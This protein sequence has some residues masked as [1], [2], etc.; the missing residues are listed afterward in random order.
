MSPSTIIA[1]DNQQAKIEVTNDVPYVS[2]SAAVAG[3][4]TSS[5]SRKD[6]GIILQVTPHINPDGFVRM[7]IKQEVSDITDSTVDIGG[8]VRA[9][10]FLKRN[11]E[12]FVT[13]K[14]NETVVLGGLIRTRDQISES[15][16]PIIGDIPL[17]GLLFRSS[18]H[19]NR[20]EELL[21]VLTPRVVRTPQDYQELSREERDKTGNISEDVLLSPLMQGLR[22]KPEDLTPRTG[23]ENIGPYPA[24]PK[25]SPDDVPADD[26]EIYGPKR[27]PRAKESKPQVDP[28]SYDV[29]VTRAMS[30]D[31]TTV[32]ARR[33]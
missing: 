17:L 28:A 4:I 19:Q 12:T 18:V 33:R 21:V 22:V 14:D 20:R 30:R 29:P 3:Q 10:I 7:E 5:V 9:P 27:S 2:G 32:E 11:A 1:M 15:K 8:G 26:P 23:E 6:V 24:T 25:P 16:I 31:R 13:V